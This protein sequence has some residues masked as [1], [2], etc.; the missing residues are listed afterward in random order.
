MDGRDDGVRPLEVFGGV[1]DVDVVA[2]DARC[3][4]DVI[5]ETPGRSDERPAGAVLGVAGL[6]ADYQ[7]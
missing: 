1:G 6:F 2:I 4:E 3:I 7:Q 5:E